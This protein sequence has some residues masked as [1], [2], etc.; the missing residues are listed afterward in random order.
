MSDVSVEP[1]V[2]VGVS[3]HLLVPHRIRSSERDLVFISQVDILPR[4][5]ELGIHFV[6]GE[7]SFPSL[8]I[9][10]F[11]LGVIPFI[12]LPFRRVVPGGF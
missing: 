4:L 7:I 3:F 2:L 8:L 11:R 9:S 5:I 12:L 10:S 1:A 6:Y